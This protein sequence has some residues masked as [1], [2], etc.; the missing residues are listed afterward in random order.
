LVFTFHLTEWQSIAGRTWNRAMDVAPVVPLTFLVLKLTGVIGWSWWWVLSPL[1]IS[2][3]LFVAGLF[4]MLALIIWEAGQGF[5]MVMP[6]VY[7]IRAETMDTEQSPGDEETMAQQ[8]KVA[9][10]LLAR[11]AL[12]SCPRR[13]PP[14]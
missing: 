7:Q 9:A 14:S 12:A 11:L 3:I 5:L 10:A 1:W 13:L 4:V 6:D 8:G 2:S